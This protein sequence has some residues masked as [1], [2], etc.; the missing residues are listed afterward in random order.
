MNFMLK[1]ISSLFFRFTFFFFF[2]LL[3]GM[4][5]FN[6]AYDVIIDWGNEK[7]DTLKERNENEEKK[8]MKQKY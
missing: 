8:N 4:F 6:D 1:I 3:A 7:I 5:I 2:C